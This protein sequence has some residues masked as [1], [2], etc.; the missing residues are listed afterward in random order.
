LPTLTF[1]IKYKVNTSVPFSAQNLKDKFLSFLPN[2]FKCN[3]YVSDDT[4]DFYIQSAQQQIESYLGIKLGRQIISETI[5]YI[6]DDWIQWGQMKVTYP[7]QLA[8]QLEGFLGNVRQLVYPP[9][10]LTARGVNDGGRTYTRNIRLVP[11]GGSLNYENTSAL[12]L[13]SFYPQINWWRTNRNIP[14]YWKVTYMTG[15]PNDIIP[16]DILQAM[17]MMATIP[18]LGIINDAYAGS[19]GLGFGVSSKSISLDG[20]SQSVNSYSDKGIFT[21][22][23]KQYNDALF[24][25]NGKPGLLEVLKDSYSAIMMT[26]C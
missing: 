11:T 7:V 22:R 2:D 24:G 13:G 21:A 12:F 19:R 25:V 1:N 15:F 8:I 9:E 26:S 20:L 10:W 18:I 14:N 5:D 17:G 4:I 23:M 16:S 3:Q 6:I